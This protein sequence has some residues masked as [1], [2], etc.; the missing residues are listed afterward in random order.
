MDPQEP[1]QTL[2]PEQINVPLPKK[3]D[4]TVLVLLALIAFAAIGTIGLFFI[5]GT[6]QDTGAKFPPP[7]KSVN[8]PQVQTATSLTTTPTTMP[9][10]P[11]TLQNPIKMTTSDG[12]HYILYGQP[13][14]QNNKAVKRIIFSLP[15]HGTA[16]EDDY[17]AWKEQLITNGN[18]ALASINWWDGKGESPSDYYSPTDVV[19]EIYYFLTS[20]NY[21]KSDFVVL[22]GFS[23][24]S[25]NTYPVVAIDVYS[26]AQVIDAVISASG[27]YQSDF[28]ITDALLNQNNGKPFSGIPW[29]LICGEKDP[30][31]TRDGCDGMRETQTFLTER[32]AKV[33]G[34]LSDPN[35]AHGSFHKSPLKLAEKALS[36]FDNLIK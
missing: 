5:S 28:A 31:P 1:Q 27:K 29:I 9:D 4:R 12:A 19:R 11:N 7:I 22:E 34:L 30:N 32:G 13:A 25:A 35:G 3:K 24:G 36:M 2:I 10:N 16:A 18:Y 33:L 17:N 14:G 21:K 6:R 26:K 15:G 23:R 8:M 20:Q